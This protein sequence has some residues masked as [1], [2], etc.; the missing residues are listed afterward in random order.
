MVILSVGE[1]QMQMSGN[2]DC[3]FI[4]MSN[5]KTVIPGLETASVPVSNGMP[6]ANPSYAPYDGRTVIPD[7][8]PRPA[9]SVTQT[10]NKPIVGFVYSISRTGNGEF[11]P[12]RVGPN[13]IGRTKNCDIYLP[14]ATVSEQHAELVVRMMKNPEKVIASIYDQRSTCGTMI[15]GESLGFEPRECVNGDIITIGEHY[16]LYVMLID[17]KQLGLNVCQAFIPVDVEQF[18]SPLQPQ[19]TN[20]TVGGTQIFNSPFSNPP[21]QAPTQQT[22]QTPPVFRLGRTVGIDGNENPT[23]PRTEPGK[24]IFM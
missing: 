4:K 10:N 1:S 6:N 14:E 8:N 2:T 5:N 21:Q 7:V 13:S 16:D 12:L 17:V 15:N 9:A 23:A 18:N 19:I 22:P 24:T 20:Q 3:D 11:W